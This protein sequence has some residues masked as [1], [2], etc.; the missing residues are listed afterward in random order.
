[1]THEAHTP[2]MGHRKRWD[3]VRPP[4]WGARIASQKKLELLVFLWINN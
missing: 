3:H 4:S 2:F 1:M